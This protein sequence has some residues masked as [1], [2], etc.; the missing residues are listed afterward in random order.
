MIITL[1]GTAFTVCFLGKKKEKGKTLSLDEFNSQHD[2]KNNTSAPN[3]EGS[4]ADMAP[5]DPKAMSDSKC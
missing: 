5:F 4:W 2:P 3:N 1:F